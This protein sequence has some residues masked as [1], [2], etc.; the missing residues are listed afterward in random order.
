[1]EREREGG[2]GGRERGRVERE[3]DREVG[4]REVERVGGERE[5]ERERGVIN[6]PTVCL[7]TKTVRISNA[8]NDY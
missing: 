2:W 1:M 8:T 6:I 7:Y 4:G 5:R 3:R